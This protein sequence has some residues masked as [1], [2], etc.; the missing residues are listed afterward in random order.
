MK[1]ANVKKLVIAAAIAAVY[2]VLTMVLAPISYGSIQCRVSEALC[3]LPFFFPASAWGLFVGC[4]IANVISAA[5]ILDIIFGSLATLLACLCTAALGKRYR[6]RKNLPEWERE[7]RLEQ[8]PSWPGCIL[9]CAMPVIFNGPIIGAVLAKMY[10]LDEGFLLSFILFGTQ[11]AIGEAVAMF[12]IG[13]PLMRYL[14]RFK[15]FYELIGG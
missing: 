5:G 7:G 12:V 10:P 9:A 1:S 8:I 11:V 3:V 14:P 4:A 15:F 13:L 6:S 2:A